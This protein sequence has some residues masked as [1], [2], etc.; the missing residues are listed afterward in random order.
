MFTTFGLHIF[1]FQTLYFQKNRLIM[2]K[3]F[4]TRFYS[5][6]Y[7]AQ[8]S[9]FYL[10]T[11]EFFARRL[12]KLHHGFPQIS[13]LLLKAPG[14][15]SFFFFFFSFQ[16]RTWQH[17]EV[18]RL[19]VKSEPQLPAYTTA[20][21]TAMPGLSLICDLHHSSEQRWVLSPLSEARD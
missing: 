14:D 9:Y 12:L 8:F 5:V 1:Y 2:S 3:N 17:M 18:P 7:K 19:G 16:G 6:L 21:A 11:F 10:V 4:L 13:S 15:Y 20:T